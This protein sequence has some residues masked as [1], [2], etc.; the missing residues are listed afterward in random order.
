[1]MNSPGTARARRWLLLLP[2]LVLAGCAPDIT[3]TGFFQRHPDGDPPSTEIALGPVQLG[4]RTVEVAATAPLAEGWNTLLLNGLV[5]HVDAVFRATT[6]DVSMPF[7]RPQA[8]A[9]E[10]GTTF[11]LFLL[12]PPA[13]SGT[14]HLQFTDG[15]ATTTLPASVSRSWQVQRLAD[16]THTL[17]WYAPHRPRTGDDR[18]ELV[19]HAFDGT[20]FAGVGN[21]SIG[22]DPYMDMGG[23]EGHSTPYSPPTSAGDGWYAA[24]INFIMSGGWDLTAHVERPGIPTDTVVFRQFE[25]Q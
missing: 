23:G 24:S 10:S 1:M 4:S 18:L 17:S 22:I 19:L 12:A 6:G 8:V 5:E 9:T 21:A 20:R 16:S 7:P 3:D 11:D 14:W 2:L 25:V 15:A 13:A